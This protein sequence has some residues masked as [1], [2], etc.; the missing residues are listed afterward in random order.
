MAFSNTS[1]LVN[2]QV[3]EFIRE[4]YPIF[5][6]FLKAYYEFLEQEQFDITTGLSLKN[7]LTTQLKDIRNVV[8]VDK[9]IEQFEDNFFNTFLTLIPKETQV[10]KE[11]LVKNILPLYLAKGADESFKLLFNLL[12]GED[13]EITFPKDNILRAS[14][15]KWEIENSIQ[16]ESV[17]RSV[18][19]GNSLSKQF[20]I[21]QPV[22]SGEI[23][24][25]VN[26]ILKQE[27]VDYEIRKESKKIIFTTAPTANSSIEVE[28]KNFD[29]NLL[30]NRR[31][32]GQSS[33]ASAIVERAIKKITT[34]NLSSDLPFELFINPKTITGSFQNGE[35]LRTNIIDSDGNLIEI[36]A[37]T[38]SV[39][40]RIDVIDGGRGHN[41]GDPVL[42]FGG[43]PTTVATAEIDEIQDVDLARIV[44][45]YSGAGFKIDESVFSGTDPITTDV[46]VSGYVD[47]IATNH[48]T[49][50]S[51]LIMGSELIDS[52]KNVVINAGDYG[53]SSAISENSSTRIVDALSKIVVTNLG[54]IA[55]LKSVYSG[56]GADL[57]IVDATQAALYTVTS[58]TFD[59]KAFKSIGRIDV[60]SGGLNYKIGDEIIFGNTFPMSQGAAAAVKTV[61]ANGAV[62]SIQIQPPRISGTS[63]VLNTT[64]EIYGTG[65]Q[66]LSDLAVGDKITFKSQEA[67]ISQI[68][69]DTWA[70]TNVAIS[71][72]DGTSWAN[73]YKIGSYSRGIVGGTNYTQNNFPSVSVSSATG[74]AANI[75]ITSLM[76][77]GENLR[78]VVDQIS[79]KITSIKITTGGG[80]YKYIPKID[81]SQIGDG[82]A[83]AE[84]TLGAAVTVF[85]GRWKTTDSIL[86]NYER[87]IQ[88]SAYYFDFSY[89][90][91]SAISFVKYK[92]I[93]KQLLHPAGFVNFAVLD[94]NRKVQTDQTSVI[95]YSSNTI[96]GTISTN[97]GS[98][99]ITGNNTKFNIANT[100]GILT[101]GSNIAVN[102]VIRTVNSIIS[103]TNLSLTSVFTT[104]SNGQTLIILT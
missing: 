87:R 59:I 66:F 83:V 36:H 7:N 2:Q 69:S 77:D 81:L 31:I 62:T 27:N 13:V 37:I 93:L 43:G 19:E 5:I 95:S 6:Q 29:Y 23:H 40:T 53:M 89:I 73:N 104:N 48:Y 94:L 44:V 33:G 38:F 55:N 56:P 101:L 52:Y 4:E 74:S 82:S 58:E 96:S 15:G 57:S 88:G 45:D 99:F 20:S 34:T 90:T 65:T 24:V 102:G 11:F 25:Y 80:G 100:R 22:N 85:P 16:I 103:N 51:M 46:L 54:P 32:T 10:D 35:E 70:Q 86:S 49:A 98:I 60:I 14:D 39:L 18:Y 97:S 21:A 67:F 3:P 68:V 61:A 63:N 26:D 84:A 79:G 30:K 8:D 28:Y 75:A 41:V 72:T 64:I 71:F 9:S 78:A 17:V 47:Q 91:S 76:G 1:I 12:Y 42:I 50:N 92:D